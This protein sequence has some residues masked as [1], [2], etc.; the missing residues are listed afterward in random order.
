MSDKKRFIATFICMWIL[1]LLFTGTNPQ[2]VYQSWQSWNNSTQE[3]V[4]GGIVSFIVSAI[5]YKFFTKNPG[6]MINPKRWGYIIAYIPAY[7]WAEIKAHLN[8]AYR[9]L[10]PSSMSPSI[11]E[12]P[13]ELESDVGLTTL[14][15]SITMTPGTLTVEI[16]EEEP[17][18]FVHWITA[19]DKTEPEQ[20]YENVGEPLEKYIRGG[21]G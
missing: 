3:F 2:S 4:V 15:D 7:I 20:A 13:T 1:W 21:F 6:D 9:V 8:V 5:S 19:E 18:L 12:V 14:A 11:V 10:K 16:D 17:K